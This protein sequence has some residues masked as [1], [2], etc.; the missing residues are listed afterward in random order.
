MLIQSSL[1]LNG[2]AYTYSNILHI[3]NNHFSL[4]V[5]DIGLL[6]FGVKSLEIWNVFYKRYFTLAICRLRRPISGN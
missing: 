4:L 6:Y 3:I 1:G 2:L 5:I